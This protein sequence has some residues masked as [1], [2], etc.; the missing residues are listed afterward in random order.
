MSGLDLGP[1]PVSGAG[2]G[3][4]IE[5]P[6]GLFRMEWGACSAGRSWLDVLVGTRF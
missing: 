5:L 2:I 6:I 3:G 1:D 4:E